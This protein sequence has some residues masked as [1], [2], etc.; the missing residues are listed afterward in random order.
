[1]VRGL[2][3]REAARDERAMRIIA[4]QLK[5]RR[6]R[7]PKGDDV[8]PTSDKVKGAL[9]NILGLRIEGA[10][11][12]DLFAGTGAVGIEAVSRGAAHALFVEADPTAR[13]ALKANL[14][15]CG[16]SEEDTDVW[17]TGGV[18]GLISH[19]KRHPEFMYDL[20]FADP[21]YHR[22]ETFR[23]LRP[24]LAGLGLAPGG[25]LVIERFH[26]MD[27]PPPV[28]PVSHLR[29]YR[30]GETVLDVYAKAESP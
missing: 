15:A 27:P 3:G 18:A 22:P 26:A 14:A 16:V 28:A 29:S 25:W 21:P 10:R 24:F 19:L 17:T 12:I 2:R 1:M 13:A 5:G 30:Y 20:V 8:R 9:F 6:L 11:V 7:A 4:G 23:L